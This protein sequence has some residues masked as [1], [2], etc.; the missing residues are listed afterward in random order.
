METLRIAC[1][2]EDVRRAS[3]GEKIE[4]AE[5]T[6]SRDISTV[7][8]SSFRREGKLPEPSSPRRR[9]G[10]KEYAG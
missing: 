4:S 5:T 2:V 8:I 6:I 7:K 3:A 10:R 1:D 9:R